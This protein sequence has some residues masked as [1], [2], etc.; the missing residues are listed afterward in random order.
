MWAA[1][2]HLRLCG[3]QETY[4]PKFGQ[5][6]PHKYSSDYERDRV[7][8]VMEGHQSNKYV[9]KLK[10]NNPF[11]SV[12]AASLQIHVFDSTLCLHPRVLLTLHGYAALLMPLS[13]H[14][15]FYACYY[16]TSMFSSRK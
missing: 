3:I 13:S 9:F 10:L 11:Q 6:P 14:M 1:F 12:V 15:G 8:F 16:Q 4:V 2:G 5:C 7:T